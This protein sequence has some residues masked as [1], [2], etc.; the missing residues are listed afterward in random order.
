MKTLTVIVAILIAFATN[1]FA[2]TVKEK[3]PCA[4]IPVCFNQAEPGQ[5]YCSTHRIPLTCS[6][7]VSVG[8][9]A[10]GAPCKTGYNVCPQHYVPPVVEKDT[11]NP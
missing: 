4:A 7:N 11:V 2:S 1:Y 9:H 10:C 6:C 3:V 5:P 8:E